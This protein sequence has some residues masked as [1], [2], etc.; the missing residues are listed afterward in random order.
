MQKVFYW[1]GEHPPLLWV[2]ILLFVILNIWFDYYH[3]FWAVVDG[4]AV[5]VVFVVYLAKRYG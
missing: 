5:V 2:V 1:L 4:I 3:P